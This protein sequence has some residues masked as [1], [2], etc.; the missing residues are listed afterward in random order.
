MSIRRTPQPDQLGFDGL[1]ASADSANFARQ[2]QQETAHLPGDLL[3]ALP[4]YRELIDHPSESVPKATAQLEL[5]S[6]YEQKQPAEANKLYQ[7]VRI[8][9]PTGVAGEIA[10]SRMSTP[11]K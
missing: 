3:D 4:F 7:Q 8:E 6:L 11:S 5:G 2:M 1:L 10:A 9:N